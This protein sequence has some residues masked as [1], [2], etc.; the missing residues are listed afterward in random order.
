MK[1][2]T[3]KILVLVVI[4]H[5]F[6]TTS[7]ALTTQKIL[8]K[9][10]QAIGKISSVKYNLHRL[11]RFTNGDTWD[12]TGFCV[13]QRASAK[14]GFIFFG[15]R[16]DHAAEFISSG[17]SLFIINRNEKTFRSMRSDLKQ[18]LGSPGGQMLV[19]DLIAADSV[20]K[21]VTHKET[22]DFY[23]LK[24]EYEDNAEF[25]ITESY[26][27]IYLHKSTFIPFKIEEHLKALGKTQTI[28]R[29]ISSLKINNE[30]DK[31]EL[32]LS[33]QLFDLRE[34]VAETPFIKKNVSTL[35]PDFSLSSFEGDR[36]SLSALKGNFVLFDFW[37]VWC[38][39]CIAAMPKVQHLYKRYKA[40]GLVV[41]GITNESENVESAKL[42]VKK[43]NV[44]YLNLIGNDQVR[45]EYKAFAVPK[46]VLLDRSLNIIYS[47]TGY[48][49]ELD[50]KIASVLNDN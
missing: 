13:I 4:C 14:P 1:A 50:A 17:K 8:E 3:K 5:P 11:D 49:E 15:K 21:S 6:I 41:I 46:Y 26:K 43:K 48:S 42:M 19:M 18:M 33:K 37:E 10:K 47:S 12:K 31:E 25:A 27:I 22:K 39:P 36:I 16:D 34:I 20:Y 29:E 28:L 9:Y 44:G 24:F 35:A 40:Q 30:V 45:E 32:N 2:S 7:Q 38:G 23:Y